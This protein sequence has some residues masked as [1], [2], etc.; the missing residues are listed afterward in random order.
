MTTQAAA[1]NRGFSKQ[2]A[3]YDD[4]DA[5]NIVLQDLRH[6][7]YSH[8]VRFLK[9]GSRIL[10]LN[11]GTGLDAVHFASQGHRVHAT[12]LSD[13]MIDAIMTKIERHNL[14]LLTCQKMSFTEI[15][16]LRE[17]N[18]D[19]VFSN[20]GGMNCISDLS[21]VTIHLPGLLNDGAYVTL[22]IMPPVSLWELGWVFKGKIK[23]ALRRLRKTGTIA[24][25]EGEYFKVYYHS[26]R[27][28]RLSMPAEL[29][30]VT[31]ESLA[32]TSPPPHCTNFPSKHPAVYEFLRRTDVLLR[33]TFPFNRWGDHLIATFQY[34]K[35]S[36]DTIQKTG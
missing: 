22:V 9:P 15:N 5:A 3:R 8:V 31:S 34:R 17:R 35:E 23:K 12:D 1:I 6:Q 36:Q 11:A 26:L 13:G 27:K 10:E 24:H 21:H 33:H 29:H 16:R 18:F 32:V 20:F 14:S 19:F 4:D 2:S 25:V 30:Y 7:V 28:I